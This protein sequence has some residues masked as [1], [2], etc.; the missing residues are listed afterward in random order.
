MHRVVVIGGGISGLSSA[1]LLLDMRPDAEVIVLEA[2]ARHGGPIRS[3]QVDGFTIEV[4]PNGF[5]NRHPSTLRLASRLGLDES[6]VTGC[7]QMRRRY[8]LSG[9]RLRRFPD[10]LKTFLST[11]LLSMRGRA[12]MMLEP[13][14][15]PRLNESDDTIG[16]FARR[17]L[18]N[19]AAE[20]LVDPVVSGIYAG[21]ADHLSLH[22]TFPQLAKIDREGRSLLRSLLLARHR[23]DATPASPTTMG[24]R[25]YVSFQNGLGELV[26]ALAA[27]IGEQLRLNS[28]VKTIERSNNGWRVEVAGDAPETIEADAVVLATPHHITQR[29][30]GVL[31]PRIEK[32][33]EDVQSAPAVVVALG[34]READVPHPL[35]GIGYLVPRAEGSRVLGVLWS[36]S[37]FPGHR[38]RPGQVLFQAVQGGARHRDICEEDDVTLISRIRM[39]LASAMSLRGEPGLSRAYR[40]PGGLPQYHL[41]HVKRLEAADEALRDLPGLFVTGNAFRGVGINACTADAERIAQ[42]LQT[43]LATVTPSGIDVSEVA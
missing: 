18:G 41:G 29:L 2:S 24:R 36:T 17:R 39:Q 22:A 25:R 3:E 8:I 21:D 12:R 16:S 13:F 27:S 9:G 20:L 30:I 42:D 1:R 14:I 33:C 23:P 37:I 5:L 4:G 38:A 11:D 32:L 6:I 35:Q 34:Y 43:Y 31:D 40:H 15:P 10:S 19:E 26:D 7:E 28:P